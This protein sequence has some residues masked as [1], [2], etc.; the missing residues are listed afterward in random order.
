[1]PQRLLRRQPLIRIKPH[2]LPNQPSQTLRLPK[3]LV[4]LPHTERFEGFASLGELLQCL[5]ERLY[6]GAIWLEIVDERAEIICLY[7]V[8]YLTLHDN[9][10]WLYIS[11]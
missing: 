8:G 7:K 11:R 6:P 4:M 2:Q 1:M 10:Q 9:G 5:H 3:P